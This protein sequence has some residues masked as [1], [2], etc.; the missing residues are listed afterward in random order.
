MNAEEGILYA[1]IDLNQ[2]FTAKRMFDVMSQLL[3]PNVI[4]FRVTNGKG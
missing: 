1:D 4:D 2:F 3:C